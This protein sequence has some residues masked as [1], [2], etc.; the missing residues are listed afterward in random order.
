MVKY[1]YITSPHWHRWASVADG[2]FY[3]TIR[4]YY[5]DFIALMG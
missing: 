5:A 4:A 2:V 1:Y 3:Y